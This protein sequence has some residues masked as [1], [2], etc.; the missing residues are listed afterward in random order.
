MSINTLHKGDDGGD[1]DDD[2][3]NNN[4]NNL[5]CHSYLFRPLECHHQGDIHKNVQVR[6]IPSKMYVSRF[7]IQYSQLTLLRIDKR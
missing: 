6:L 4:N 7:R 5:T 3:N 2:D 1:D